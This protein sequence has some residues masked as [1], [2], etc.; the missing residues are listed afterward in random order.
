METPND[1]KP[2][3]LNPVSAALI[4]AGVP[5][6]ERTMPSEEE[7]TAALSWWIGCIGCD[8]VLS[9]HEALIHAQTLIDALQA[10]TRDKRGTSILLYE[11]LKIAIDEIRDLRNFANDNGGMFGDEEFREGIAAIA[12]YEADQ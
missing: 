9:S 3:L 11:A 2:G 10:S 5:S 6:R 7:L 4:A 12:Q 8:A 1:T